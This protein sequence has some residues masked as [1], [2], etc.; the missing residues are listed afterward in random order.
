MEYS[1][2]YVFSLNQ[3]YLVLVGR[4]RAT[5]FIFLDYQPGNFPQFSGRTLL[6]K[7]TINIFRMTHSDN[8][9]ESVPKEHQS[10][11]RGLH[12]F[13]TLRGYVRYGT[14]F[15][16]RK[17]S[18]GVP[19]SRNLSIRKWLQIREIKKKVHTYLRKVN[20]VTSNEKKKRK[21]K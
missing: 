20:Q 3:S 8:S 7:L 13:V 14:H 12:Y 6:Y 15:N 2:T 19:S 4:T 17:T 9:S 10:S 16:T 1:Y 5:L 18:Y 21:K 11:C